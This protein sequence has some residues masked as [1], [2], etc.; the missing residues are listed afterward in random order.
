MCICVCICMYLCVYLTIRALINFSYRPKLN[1]YCVSG[2]MLEIPNK[3]DIPYSPGIYNQVGK[4][5][6]A[7]GD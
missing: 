7:L 4:E 5:V 3:L 1:T 2:F 6:R